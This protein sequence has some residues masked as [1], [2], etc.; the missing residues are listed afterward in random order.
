MMNEAVMNMLKIDKIKDS[1]A[2]INMKESDK[3]IILN[4]VA[5]N[6]SKSLGSLKRKLKSRYEDAYN[7]LILLDEFSQEQVTEALKEMPEIPK[8]DILEFCKKLEI[9]HS[10]GVNMVIAKNKSILANIKETLYS[11][12]NKFS[13]GNCLFIDVDFTSPS[14]KETEL[15]GDYKLIEYEFVLY[16]LYMANI[17]QISEILDKQKDNPKIAFNSSLNKYLEEFKDADEYKTAKKFAK[18]IY[19]DKCDDKCVIKAL[20]ALV[21]SGLL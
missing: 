2:E 21:E 16:G 4:L 7:L 17:K 12:L 20:G 5:L 11:P 13:E 15:L 6:S 1:I 9:E 14:Y 19:K 3:A 18:E 8:E 10:L